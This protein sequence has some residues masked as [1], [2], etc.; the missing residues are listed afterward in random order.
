[1]CGIAGYLGTRELSEDQVGAALETMRRRGPDNSAWRHWGLVGGRHLYL[2]NSR[3]SIIDANERSNQPIRSGDT[4]LTVNGELYNYVELRS[5][6]TSVGRRFSTESDSEVLAAVIDQDGVSGLD[7]CEGMWAFAAFRESTGELIICRDRFGEKPLHLYR[8][9]H[10]IYFASEVSALFALLGKRLS[11]DIDHLMRYV[12]H[13]YKSLYKQPNSFFEGI[14]ELRPGSLL[15]IGSDGVEREERYWNPVIAP[16]QEMGVEE[17]IEGARERLFRAVELRL[18]SDVPIAFCMSGGIDSVSLIS[19]AR[20]V[21]DY[22]VHGFT[23]VNTD[24]RYEES[25]L[26]AHA[27]AELGIQHTSV[28]LRRTGFL[29]G[30]RELISY[31]D[32]PVYTLTYY[33]H[34]RLLEEIARH[35]Y[36]ISVS[37]TAADELFSGYFDHHLAYLYE[38]RSDRKA[39]NRAVADWRESVLP[40][41]RNKHLRDP[42]LFINNP[43]FRDH[44][45]HGSSVFQ[46]YLHEPWEDPFTEDH[47]TD[48]LLRNRMLNELF[49]ET[50]PVIL[51][52]DDLNSMYHSVENRSPYLDRELF[53]FCC[54]IPTQ[55][56]VK[57]GRAKAVLRA[58]MGGIAPDRILE[59]PRKVGF[60]AP[61][62]DLLDTNEPCVR[63]E[64]LGDSPIYEYL[65]RD[66][67]TDL[68]G[69]SKLSNSESKF[70]FNLVNAK[71]FLEA[72]S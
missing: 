6:L 5:R 45:Y 54:S 8:A 72:Y 18:R 58:A 46:T 43:Q 20:R 10:G 32:A 69:K 33:M 19:I 60:N 27:V 39:F 49:H 70:L 50:V 52:E 53:N 59:N 65:K 16:N 17:A 64:L 44:I 56:L 23:I 14:E 31:H 3:L 68:M 30:L 1:M 28:P 66:M 7:R 71:I 67:V 41:V 22:D 4:W 25:E 55:H 9:P 51:H 15:R 57:A 29:D 26:V 13:S 62:Q 63:A 37:G 12:T 36:R 40:V 38:I 24:S 34:W 47:F 48:D 35:G 61:I 21:F 11:I 42:M 2:L